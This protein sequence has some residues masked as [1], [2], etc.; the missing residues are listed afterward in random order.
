MSIL[1]LTDLTDLAFLGS[2]ARAFLLGS[3]HPFASALTLLAC[4]YSRSV[5]TVLLG[6]HGDLLS[7]RQCS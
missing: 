3:R 5:C 6:S 4:W 1:N 2:L 7:A